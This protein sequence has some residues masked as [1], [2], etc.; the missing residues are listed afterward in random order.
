MASQHK[1]E[2]HDKLGE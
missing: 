2:Y 1:H